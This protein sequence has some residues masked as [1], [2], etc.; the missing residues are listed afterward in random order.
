MSRLHF[1]WCPNNKVITVRLHNLKLLKLT[2]GKYK[3]IR[4]S[5]ENYNWIIYLF[6]NKIMALFS[7]KFYPRSMVN[8]FINRMKS[9]KWVL[10][11]ADPFITMLYELTCRHDLDLA[12]RCTAMPHALTMQDMADALLVAYLSC[13]PCKSGPTFFFVCINDFTLPKMFLKCKSLIVCWFVMR[14]VSA[15]ITYRLFVF[16]SPYSNLII[17]DGISQFQISN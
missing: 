5:L 11:F 9:F 8:S 12:G 3:N 14:V 1:C 16:D 2:Q 15:A 13:R 10:S 17:F 4:T 7:A 6:L